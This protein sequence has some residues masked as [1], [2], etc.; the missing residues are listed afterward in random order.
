MAVDEA[1]LESA[2]DGQCALR[3]YRWEEP[4]LSLGYFQEYADRQRHPASEHCPVVRRTSGGGAILHDIEL[5]YSIAVPSS[6]PLA[7]NRLK[8]YQ[9]VHAALIATLAQ[10][11][12]EATMFVSPDRTLAEDTPSAPLPRP[13]D[14]QPFLCFE[15]RSPG[16]VLVGGVKV[17]GSAQRRCR[18]AVLQHGS[19]LLAQSAAAPELKGLKELTATTVTAEELIQGWLAKLAES[20]AI[21]WRSG[22]LSDRDLRRGIAMATEKHTSACWIKSRGRN[23]GIL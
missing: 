9:T 22:G 21:T 14:R 4:T 6:H 2:T 10:W 17:A 19:V 16:D 1:L 8:F 20:L 23:D 7:I 12:I 11:G 13:A 5:T 18:G 3:F 15:R